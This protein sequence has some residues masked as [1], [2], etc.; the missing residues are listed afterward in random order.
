MEESK[1]SAS[2]SAGSG[3]ASACVQNMR[4]SIML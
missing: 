1:Y 2:S 4:L 3:P